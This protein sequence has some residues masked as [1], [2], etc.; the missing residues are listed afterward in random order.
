MAGISHDAPTTSLAD[1]LKALIRC[2]RELWLIYL[3]T[4]LEYVGIFTFLPTLPLWLSGDFGMTDKQAG[5]WAA[6]FSTLLTLFV[7]L[8]GSLAD[9]IGVRRM[10][11]LSFALAAVTRLWMALAGSPSMAITALLAFGLAYATTSPVLQTAIQRTSTRSTRAFAFSLW[12]VSFNVSG[13]LSGPIIDETRAAFLD[14]VT[15][16]LVPHMVNVPILG[17]RMMSAHAFIMGLGFIS[18]ALAVLVVLLLRRDFEHRVDPEDKPEVAEP[19][20]IE[21]GLEPATLD[22]DASAAKPAVKVAEPKKVNPLVALKEVVADRAFWRFMLLLLLLCLVRMMFQ[23]MHFTWPKYITRVMGDDFPV[24]KVW[25][26]NSLL[27]LVLAPLGTAITRKQKP[28][29]VLLLGAFISSCSPFVLCFG[30]TMPYQIGMVLFLTVG[31]ALWSPRLYEYNVSIAPRGREATY[32]SLAALPYFAAKFLVGPTSGYL[33][34]TYCPA[35]GPRNPAILWG[36]IG[37]ATMIGPVGILM[38]R[39]VIQKKELEAAP[40]A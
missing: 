20:V 4:F 23:H 2:P 13:T 8:V 19:E 24:G 1:D 5:N 38:L 32:V 9:L 10:L 22:K 18:A 29:N 31:E 3:A 27:I 12:Y 15:K 25:S 40:A 28:F 7:F 33:L 30:S 34:A 11:I 16:K 21:P 39:N 6:T 14:P 35:E 36:V 37:F 17:P 26:L